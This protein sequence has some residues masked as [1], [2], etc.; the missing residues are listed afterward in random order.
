MDNKEILVKLLVE[1]NNIEEK[2]SDNDSK[3]SNESE[4]VENVNRYKDIVKGIR[5]GMYNEQLE[6]ERYA[7]SLILD[8]SDEIPKCIFHYTDGYGLVAILQSNFL[9]ATNY[10]FLNDPMEVQSGVGIVSQAIKDLMKIK[11]LSMDLTIFL[12]DILK[13]DY[14]STSRDDLYITCFCESG[15]LL[16]QWRAYGNQGNGYSIGFD[17]LGLRNVHN[18]HMQESNTNNII[19]GKVVYK[20]E[21]KLEIINAILEKYLDV[22]SSYFQYFEYHEVS[23]IFRPLMIKSLSRCLAFFKDEAYSEENEWRA[24]YIHDEEETQE[25]NNLEVN[26]RYNGSFIVPYV[27]LPLYGTAYHCDKL[28]ITNI[29]YGPTSSPSHNQKSLNMLLRSEKYIHVKV[30]SSKINYIGK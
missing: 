29:I 26:F 9:W 6:L 12:M 27:A 30:N 2:L 7:K 16:S 23:R 14:Y 3:N 17:T 18:I 24:I 20:N 22:M 25:S 5:K 10:K 15:D 13:Y 4:L 28:A 1:I 19:L 8:Q 21:K 11:Q